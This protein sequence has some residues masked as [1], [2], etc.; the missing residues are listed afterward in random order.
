M[1]PKPPPQFLLSIM[2]IPINFPTQSNHLFRPREGSPAD[3][4][5]HTDPF[6][7]DLQPQFFA[8]GGLGMNI[9][10]HLVQTL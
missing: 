2:C 5:I 3:A 8:L 6:P 1:V 4:T 10:L 9:I 7:F